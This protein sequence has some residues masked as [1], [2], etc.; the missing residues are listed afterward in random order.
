MMAQVG[1]LEQHFLLQDLQ[2]VEVEQ[3]L[4]EEHVE[5]F[6]A[7]VQHTHLVHHKQQIIT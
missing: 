3:L 1:H 4:Q 5:V 7:Q 2:K 6:L